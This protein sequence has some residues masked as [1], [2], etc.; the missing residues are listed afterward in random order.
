MKLN[1]EVGESPA[2]HCILAGRQAEASRTRMC[3][4]G[5]DS[6]REGMARGYGQRVCEGKRCAEPVRLTS[7]SVWVADWCP[8]SSQSVGSLM[9]RMIVF[10]R[11]SR[12]L[13]RC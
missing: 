13:Q 12:G 11:R 9:V 5:A 3:G 4:D 1:R 2:K 7:N 6:T 10:P 8:G